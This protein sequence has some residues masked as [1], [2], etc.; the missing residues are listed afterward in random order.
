LRLPAELIDI[1]LDCLSPES[2][3]CLALTCRALFVRYFP[4]PAPLSDT[5]KAAFLQ[6]LER[7]HPSLYFCHDCIRLHT[8]HL[9]QTRH[10]IWVCSGPCLRIR[11]VNGLMG[12]HVSEYGMNF[13]YSLARIVMNRHLY[14][15]AHGPSAKDMAVTNYIRNVIHDI[16]I[17]R[18]WSAKIINNGLYL[19]G[20]MVYQSLS[21]DGDF[22]TLRDSLQHLHRL[23]ICPH[24]EPPS[25]YPA[26]V[27]VIPELVWDCDS[28][29]DVGPM[30][31]KIRSCRVCFTDYRID[32]V[33][34]EQRSY[35]GIA[36]PRGENWAVEINR[37]H[38][39]GGCRSP[40]DLEW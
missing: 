10:G 12:S 3:I 8:W 6:Y 32:I 4:R 7:D 31:G 5:A 39:L 26:W 22:R 21:K 17:A 30:S 24:L 28:P 40:Y 19:H 14:G 27:H 16:S 13:T 37:W 29:D 15:S 18:S 1:I 11:G 25:N 38:K 23:L 34:R 36:W 9:T 20:R 2:V 35:C 33:L